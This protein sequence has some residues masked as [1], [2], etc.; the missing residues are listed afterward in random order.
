MT[1]DW[2]QPD[3]DNGTSS[4]AAATQAA[5]SA[6]NTVARKQPCVSHINKAGKSNDG[7]QSDLSRNRQL[8]QLRPERQVEWTTSY[9]SAWTS[10]T[11]DAQA[12]SAS[13]PRRLMRRSGPNSNSSRTLTKRLTTR[14]TTPP[15]ALRTTTS[16]P[17]VPPRRPSR[18]RPGS[19]RV[20]SF[21]LKTPSLPSDRK[22]SWMLL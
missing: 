4:S 6:A 22:D 17:T 1:G 20:N 3:A 7:H 5:S 15:T 16:S 2:Q 21:P 9:D 12:A 18:P 11:A 8:R 19:S 10:M 13:A 14:T